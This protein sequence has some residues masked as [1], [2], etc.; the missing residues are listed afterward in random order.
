VLA[1][2]P[3]CSR[4][5]PD[6][7]LRAAPPFAVVMPMRNVSVLGVK[8]R[9]APAALAGEGNEAARGRPLWQPYDTAPER[10]A[11]ELLRSK[12]EPANRQHQ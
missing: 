10:N 7:L 8:R 6:G 2:R 4:A 11:A 1:F 12:L 9:T 5:Q 3:R